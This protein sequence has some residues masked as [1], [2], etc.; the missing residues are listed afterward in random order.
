MDEARERDYVSNVQGNRD[1]AAGCAL[2]I[3]GKGAPI[4]YKETQMPPTAAQRWTQALV[5]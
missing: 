4:Q 1:L 5:P 2:Q 3:S